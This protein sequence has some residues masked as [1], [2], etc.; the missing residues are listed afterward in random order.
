MATINRNP[1]DM[2]PLT[3]A[4]FHILLTLADRERHG[5]SIMK[6]VEATTGDQIKMGPGTLYGAIKRLLNQGIIEKTDERADSALNDKRRRYYRLTEFGQKVLQADAERKEFRRFWIS[7]GSVRIC[8]ETLI[9]DSMN[10]TKLP[11]RVPC[12]PHGFPIFGMHP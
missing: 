1:E 12:Q 4:V 10:S 2:I 3:P 11:G 6:E 5:Y 7:G 8:R 9:H